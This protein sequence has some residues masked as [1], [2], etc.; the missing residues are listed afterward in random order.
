MHGV[1]GERPKIRVDS[2]LMDQVF[3]TLPP[4]GAGLVVAEEVILHERNPELIVLSD[5]VHRSLVPEHGKESA[6][7]FKVGFCFPCRTLRISN[8][9]RPLPVKTEEEAVL[10]IRAVGYRQRSRGRPFISPGFS[11]AFHDHQPILSTVNERFQKGLTRYGAS[12]VF[13]LYR[14]EIT[15]SS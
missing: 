3:D 8:D 1:S 5:E 12:L 2:M 11:A 4:T 7:D 15:G 6:D 9:D 13:L 10:A 14:D